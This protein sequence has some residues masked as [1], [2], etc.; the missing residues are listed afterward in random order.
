MKARIAK[1][2]GGA[3]K[4]AAGAVQLPPFEEF[5]TAGGMKVILARREPIPLV[6]VRLVLRAGSAVDPL[7]RHG[8]ADFTARLL[9]RGT[10]DLSADGI[11]DA[12]EFV[13]ASLGA[14]AAE[15]YSAEIGRAH[16]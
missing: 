2:K 14:G 1:A 5:E 8:L 3:K 4:P 15:D 9:R 12:V 16:V 6:S 13:G 10:R 7:G 11:N